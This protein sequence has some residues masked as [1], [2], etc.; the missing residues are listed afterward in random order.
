MDAYAKNFKR[1]G[2]DGNKD[3]VYYGKLENHRYYTYKD[4]EVRKGKAKR[5]DRK[6][7]EQMHVQIIVSRKDASNTI[8]LSPLNNSR[9]T[10]AVHSQ[11]VGQFDR[12]AFKQVAE[13]VFDRMFGYERDIGSPFVMPTP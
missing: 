12:V 10:N 7:D 6:P 9:G 5:G 11:Q 1:N 8:K 4:L 2:I 13:N 3:L